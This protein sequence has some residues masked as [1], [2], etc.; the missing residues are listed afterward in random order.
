MKVNIVWHS[1]KQTGISQDVGILRGILMAMFDKEIEIFSV[2]HAMPECKDADYNIF[3]EVI[4]PSLFSYARKNIWIPNPEWTYKAWVPY[5]NMVDEI[6]C[7]TQEAVSIFA[8]LTPTPIRYIG[9]TSI[10]K[11]WNPDK[12]RKNYY[13]AI[14]P[15][16]KN[17]YRHPKPLLQAYLRF[18]EKYPSEYS[19]L[20]T[21]YIV[22]DPNVIQ[23]T[24]PTELNDKVI[25]KGEVLRE[26]AYDELLSECGVCMCFS[27]AE[28]FCHAVN[29]AMS[30][31]CNLILSPI[32]PF[33]QDLA[34]EDQNGVFYAKPLETVPQPDKLG[35]FVDSDVNSIVEQLKEYIDTDFKDRKKGSLHIRELYETRHKKWVEGMKSVLAES[36]PKP[37]EPYSLKS[38][39]PKE[40]DLPD[41]SIVTI[42]KDRRVF[43]PLAK[44]S[45]MIQ[46][47]PEE[48]L[49][50]IIVDDGED[51][52]EDTLI[53][54]PNVVYVRCESGLTISQ[55]RNLGVE[56]AMYDVICFM[57]DDDVYPNNSVLQRVAMLLKQPTKE[58]GFCTT[59]PCYDITQFSS[60]MN[61]PPRQ[62]PMSE[63]VSEASL[64]FTRKFWSEGKFVDDVQIGEGDAFVRGREHMC[65]EISPQEVIVSLIHPKNTSS[66]RSPK[67]EEPNGC[68]Y[69][70]NEKLFEV[71]SQIGQELNNAGQTDCASGA[72]VPR[73]ET[74]ETQS[75]ESCA[76]LPPAQKEP[77][78]QQA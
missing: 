40:E 51:P 9:W 42:T 49:E 62:L 15:V 33:K 65:R 26:S 2:N 56:K 12:T 1:Q 63:R 43:M 5:L 30:A 41:V 16:G 35:V 61:V 74:H 54:V 32:Q 38:T 3:V 6:W 73:G 67:F 52:I 64:V 25:L 37:D 60:F 21:L 14:V 36:M 22:Y 70:F 57:D 47:Y 50:W 19:K 20:P 55:K 8:P 46:S 45:Y 13:K 77:Q 76:H 17:L 24:V 75:D 71:V 78:V 69:G 23:V 68:H 27:L 34:G 29:E 72:C 10:D 39:L 66:R 58:C 18:L 53:G 31:G 7:K 4:N 11:V 59:I 28:G 48:K 44:Y